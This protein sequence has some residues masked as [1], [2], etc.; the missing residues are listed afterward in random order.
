MGFILYNAKANSLDAHCLRHKGNPTLHCV[1]NRTVAEG[2]KQAQGR[3][4]GF[5]VAWLR[6]ACRFEHGPAGRDHHFLARLG[7]T[8]GMEFLAIGT[9]AERQAARAWVKHAPEMRPLVERE[10]PPHEG[11]PEEPL[12]LP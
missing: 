3:P 8:K 4:L 2:R 6:C 10:R 1:V 9:S 7:S 5:L 11:E 12:G